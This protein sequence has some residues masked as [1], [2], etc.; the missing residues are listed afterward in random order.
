MSV[1]YLIGGIALIAA[2]F[3]AMTGFSR[4][5][6][7]LLAGI[8]GVFAARSM[9]GLVG[10][11]FAREGNLPPLAGTMIVAL[12]TF[13]L[14]FLV[15]RLVGTTAI[16][17]LIEQGIDGERDLTTDRWLGFVFGLVKGLAFAYVCLCLVRVL[18]GS[19]QSTGRSTQLFAPLRSS[20]AYNLAAQNNVFDLPE[21]QAIRQLSFLQYI[22]Q[23]PERR[24]ALVATKEF[25]ALERDPDLAPVAEALKERRA[26]ELNNPESFKK[27]LEN[28]D[29]QKYLGELSKKF[30]QQ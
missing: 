30:N 11:R 9:S 29:V 16:R 6:A 28:T 17:R 10:E 2:L 12:G 5:L 14:V 25:R 3:G 7:Q 24:A 22:A 23:S 20:V 21:L 18:E 19:V 4:Q 26:G 13:T 1:D 8:A 15:L 27:L